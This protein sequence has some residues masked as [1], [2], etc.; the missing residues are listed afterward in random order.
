MPPCPCR[1]DADIA[2]SSGHSFPLDLEPL[3]AFVALACLLKALGLLGHSSASSS[4]GV[5][6]Q[7]L[8][9]A[10]DFRVVRFEQSLKSF[11]GLPVRADKGRLLPAHKELGR[12][13]LLLQQCVE[14]V[15]SPGCLLGELALRIPRNVVQPYID[16][17]SALAV[18][19]PAAAIKQG[20][21]C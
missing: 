19:C 16:I 5:H 4:G 13:Q 12:A 9:N 10:A 3:Q 11:G 20:Q 8:D 18:V 6:S 7:I 21:L 2:D 17:I 1:E 14:P 15:D